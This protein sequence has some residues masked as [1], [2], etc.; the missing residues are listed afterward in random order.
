MMSL[1]RAFDDVYGMHADVANS[2]LVLPSLSLL[3]GAT[4]AYFHGASGIAIPQAVLS[5][6]TLALPLMEVLAMSRWST[7]FTQSMQRGNEKNI[8]LILYITQSVPLLL[9]YPQFLGAA[10][11][12]FKISQV[13]LAAIGPAG[14][15]SC[16]PTW[17]F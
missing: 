12:P 15:L 7:S 17:I 4:R 14:V 10:M 6:A 9:R 1:R 2:G 16:L 3:L 8:P 13:M 11:N 5:V